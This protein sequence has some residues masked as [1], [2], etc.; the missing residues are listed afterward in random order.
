MF[1]S[2]MTM[3]EMTDYVIVILLFIP[4]IL[5]LIEVM[6][7][8]NVYYV[9]VNVLYVIGMVLKDEYDLVVRND[10][11]DDDGDQIEGADVMQK[12]YSL[13]KDL[14]EENGYEMADASKMNAENGKDDFEKTTDIIE[15]KV[16]SVRERLTEIFPSC[17]NEHENSVLNETNQE[18]I[19][20]QRSFSQGDGEIWFLNNK[21]VTKVM[22]NSSQNED[23]TENVE[24]HQ[25][26]E[27][28]IEEIDISNSDYSD[29]LIP[30]DKNENIIVENTKLE[31]ELVHNELELIKENKD[32]PNKD[33]SDRLIKFLD[34]YLAKCENDKKPKDHY[35]K[36]DVLPTEVTY[37]SEMTQEVGETKES[38][39]TI[40]DEKATENNIVNDEIDSLSNY[41]SCEPAQ[42]SVDDNHSDN[43]GLLNTEKHYPYDQAV[44]I[45]IGTAHKWPDRFKRPRKMRKRYSCK[46]VD[47]IVSKFYPGH[48]LSKSQKSRNKTKNW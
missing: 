1:S 9:A 45:L 37:S 21:D 7:M 35:E 36:H 26:L 29:C 30:L 15:K 14:I 6:L 33:S 40:H 3:Y 19:V 31:P 25:G 8:G 17:S 28:I 20:P 41:C 11:D 27:F 42:L 4:W 34:K 16:E 18:C 24:V 5:S 22:K 47:D 32:I 23:G 39:M 2:K 13:L 43:G 38:K 44:A 46:T 48:D 12:S 10:D